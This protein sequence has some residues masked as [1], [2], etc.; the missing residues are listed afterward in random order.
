MRTL[1]RASCTKATRAYPDWDRHWQIIE[2]HRVNAYYTAPTLIRSFVKVGPEYPAKHDLSSLRL[3]GTVGE[4]INPEAWLWYWRHIGGER[5]PIVDTWWQ[6]ETGGILITPLPGLTD[7]KPGSA[8]VPFPGIQADILDEA[9]E[10]V[11]RGSG[12]F[13]VVKHPWPGMF[14]TLWEDDERY[15]DAYFS[16]YDP[17][18]YVVG[19][20]AKQDDDGYFWIMGRIDDVINVSG[21]RLSTTED[22][23]D[24]GRA[25]GGRRGCS[26]RCR[27]PRSRPSDRLLRPP[28]GQ[29]RAVSR[30]GRGAP[31]VRWREDRQDRSTSRG[32]LR[33]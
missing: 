29:P 24:P 11:P 32:A 10:P 5:C 9:G 30:A 22:R 18:I 20:G 27:R 17:S 1:Q 4:P 8:T 14:R 26:D 2:E 6:T 3:L 13:L 12:G 25:C 31:P 21:H 28:Q 16:K 7:L 15:V 23:V 33:R 19:D